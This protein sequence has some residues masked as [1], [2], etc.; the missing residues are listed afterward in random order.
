MESLIND[1]RY[2]FRE[3]RKRPSFTITAVLS[4]ALG[5]GA[6]SAVFSVIYA[7]LI[8][9]FP[10]PHSDRIVSIQLID[11]TGD[12]R[13]TGFSGL[14]IEQLRQ[15]K[16]FESVVADQGWNLTTTDGDI[17]ED[18]QTLRHFHR[19]PNHWGVPAMLGRW[20]MPSDAPPGQDAATR[21][22]PS[23]TISG[24]AIS[25]AIQTSSAVNFSSSTSRTKSL[26]S[27]RHDSSGAERRLPPS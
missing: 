14:A 5:I 23:V 19:L 16:S 21:R 18:V 22:G 12:D 24:K 6:T 17:P 20:L 1:L 13:G 25:S 2:I 27:C 9:P 26:A 15:V 4:L 8:D 7:V 11:K 10:Y 3:F